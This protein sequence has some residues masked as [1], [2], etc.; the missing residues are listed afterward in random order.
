MEQIKVSTR[1]W[2]AW[3]TACKAV[4]ARLDE[5]FHRW[6]STYTKMYRKVGARLDECF[7]RWNSTYTKMYRKSF[8]QTSNTSGALHVQFSYLIIDSFDPA[9]RK[10][11]IAFTFQSKCPKLSV[12]HICTYQQ[13]EAV[14]RK[15][16][17]TYFGSNDEILSPRWDHDDVRPAVLIF[18]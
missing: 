6:N 8:W 14:W 2:V 11:K 13:G 16:S 7:H 4:G 18:L 3:G 12:R 17:W 10:R 1:A 9:R 5:C 15:K